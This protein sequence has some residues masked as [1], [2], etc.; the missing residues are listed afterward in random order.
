MRKA[1]TRY[2]YVRPGSVQWRAKVDGPLTY[3]LVTVDG[4][5]ALLH[6]LRIDCYHCQTRDGTS[7]PRTLTSLVQSG[8]GSILTRYV[9]AS[10]PAETTDPT[11]VALCFSGLLRNTPITDVV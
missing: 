1:H 9:V 8:S 6:W 10:A 2:T 11:R 3:S 5:P 4:V 7:S